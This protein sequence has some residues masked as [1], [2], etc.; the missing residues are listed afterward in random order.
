MPVTDAWLSSRCIYCPATGEDNLVLLLSSLFIT[1]SCS[2]SCEKGQKTA[3]HVISLQAIAEVQV[4]PF[5]WLYR[6]TFSLL[7]INAM[8]EPAGYGKLCVNFKIS[9]PQLISDEDLICLRFFVW[10]ILS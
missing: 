10:S 9:V 4:L 7:L 2:W 5:H 3:L 8:P 6:Q 1:W